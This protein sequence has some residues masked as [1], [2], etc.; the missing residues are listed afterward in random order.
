MIEFRC[1]RLCFLLLVLGFTFTQAARGQLELQIDEDLNVS[2]VNTSEGAIQIKGYQIVSGSGLLAP[3]GWNSITRQID[4]NPP[5]SVLEIID[6]FTAGALTFGEA[7]SDAGTLAELF[8]FGECVE[9]F[10]NNRYFPTLWRYLRARKEDAFAFF[11]R[12]QYHCEGQGFFGRSPTQPL[13]S[14]LLLGAAAD[15]P[16]RELI[17]EILIHD[18]L[19]CGHHFVPDHLGPIDFTL[20]RRRLRQDLPH[21][22]EGL[23]DYRSRDQFLKQAIFATFS[24]VALKVIGLPTKSPTG[25]IAFLPEKTT[26]IMK[27]RKT[28]LVRGIENER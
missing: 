5:D 3:G 14:E 15:R 26:D 12:L 8:R 28:I 25:V 17:R 21:R 9:V 22:W 24:G 11:S 10:H 20:L 16:D 23:Y 19:R 6:Q 18:W 13:L 4:S 27:L 2:I 7:R 1:I